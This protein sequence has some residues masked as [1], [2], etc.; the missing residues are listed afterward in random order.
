MSNKHLH[1]SEIPIYMALPVSSKKTTNEKTPLDDNELKQEDTS[2][3][4]IDIESLSD[5]SKIK[6]YGIYPDP[7]K[8]E[9]TMAL[10]KRTKRSVQSVC[11]Y[12]NWCGIFDSQLLPNPTQWKFNPL[13]KQLVE[14]PKDA[15]TIECFSPTESEKLIQLCE[16]YGFEDCGYPKGYRSN[17]RLITSDELLANNL[18]ERIKLVCPKRYECDDTIWEICGLNERFR[19]CKYVKGQKFGMHCDARYVRN[20]KEKS[21]Y[22]VNIYLN[23]G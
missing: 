21:F 9:T 14:E 23:D 16:L 2:D 3:T 15:F 22:T 18:Y 13:S 17:T 5:V 8:I 20:R 12:V 4:K 11:H 6:Y 7:N 1:P 19:C 10:S